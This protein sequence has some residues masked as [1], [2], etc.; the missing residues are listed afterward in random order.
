[1]PRKKPQK[2]A[3]QKPANRWLL[4]VFV[5]LV[6]AAVWGIAWWRFHPKIEQAAYPAVIQPDLLKVSGT[7]PAEARNCAECHAKEVAEWKDSQ[8]ANANRLFNP[9]TD[10]AAFRHTEIFAA[11][12]SKTILQNGMGSATA[13]VIEPDGTRT[14]YHPESVIGV[15]PLVQYLVS[16]PAGRLQVLNYSF[17]P[18]KKEWFDSQ[19][20][21]TRLPEDWSHW[22][23]RGMNWNSQCAFCHMTNLRKGYDPESDSYRT[24]WD[25]MGIACAQCHGPMEK[26]ADKPNDKAFFNR[27]DVKQ[28][29]D[30]CGSCHARREELTGNF[31]AGEKFSDHYRLSLPDLNGL[32]YPDGQ[33]KEEDYEYGS[34]TMSRMGHKGVSCLDCHNPHSGKL[35]APVENNALCMTCH[36][37]PGQRGAIPIDPATHSHHKAGTPG[38][39]CVD[40]HMPITRYM[41]RDPRRDHGFTIPDP[42]LTRELGVPNSCNR[43]HEDKSVDWSIEATVKWYGDKME[44]RSRERARVIARMEKSDDT[45]YP[46]LLALAKSEEIAAWRSV[47]VSLLAPWARQP[48][49]RSFLEKSLADESPLVRSAAVRA[50][51]QDPE[52]AALIKPLC[53]DPSRLV[54]LDAVW[55]LHEGRDR[56]H[57]SYGELLEY[58]DTICDQPAGAL[59][60]AQFALD[61]HRTEDALKWS[62]KAAAWD[63]TSGDAYQVHAVVLNSAGKRDEA[64]AELRRA[65]AV[66][67]KNARHPF[68]L[69]LLCGEAG[70]ADE[71]IVQLKKAVAI[72]PAFGRAW[73]NLGLALAQKEQLEDSIA[74][75]RRAEELQPGAPEIPYARATVHVRAGEMN[76][77]RKAAVRAQSLGSAPA[78]EML[79]ELPQ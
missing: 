57:A 5:I 17:D 34:F 14:V 20:P 52:A 56:S 13:A 24:T 33:V 37:A 28:I 46:E 60:K 58:L 38:D 79:R 10:L 9:R 27:L 16:F 66:D 2:T 43:C 41:V 77:A 70:Q 18:E 11:N 71:V 55:D 29:V 67:P 47:L 26:H 25:A 64:M 1:M 75:L 22:T 69:A 51:A 74:A 30:N 44:R 76:E 36:A 48:D 73:Y 23:H 68:M 3:P 19:A 12:G 72:D 62:A 59:R 32:Y 7:P 45:V 21:E 40:C 50:L 6:L 63:A 4:P 35:R 78:A 8:H 49:A 53:D 61:E 54:R 15:T 42:V 39:R 31:H 65:A